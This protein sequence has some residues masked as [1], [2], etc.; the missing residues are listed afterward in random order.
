MLQERQTR[1]NHF[2]V[3]GRYKELLK[4]YGI[5]AGEVL[6][7]AQLPEDIL[8]HSPIT[9]KEEEYYRFLAAVGAVSGKTEPAIEFATTQ[10]IENF[11]PPIF[12][13]YCS[14]N[15]AVCIQRLARYKKLIGPMTF[16]IREEA[17][18]T[19]VELQAGDPDLVLPQ[20]LVLGEF[21]F[22]TGMIRSATREHVVPVRVRM[23]QP[24]DR[25][26][27]TAFFDKKVEQA[28]CSAISFS[29]A[30]LHLPFISWND[31]MWSYF[32]PE[33][34]KRLVDLEADDSTSA[35][36]RSALTELLPG[37]MSSI[38]DAAQKLGISRRTLQ[39]RLSEENTTFQ[40]QLNNTR[41][42]LAIHYIQNTDMSANDIAYLLGYSE[43][44][45]F[46]RAFT[47]W[48]GKSVSAYRKAQAEPKQ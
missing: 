11:S 22:L 12:A 1:M 45:S 42:I 16:V 44:N 26:A 29:N 40:K 4:Y 3:D 13:S 18:T 27:V 24:L 20:F 34:S 14:R 38:D 47:V 9:M 48:T 17:D 10:K 35:R 5:D 25:E 21:A 19:T 30:D 15:G 8:N 41:E 39:R 23:K 28:D 37:G 36:V 7:K 2:I 43:L 46:L 32:E 31:A 33:L 6:K